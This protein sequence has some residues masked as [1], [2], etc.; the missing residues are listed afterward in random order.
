MKRLVLLSLCAFLASNGL[1]SV[2]RAM[3]QSHA[4]EASQNQAGASASAPARQPLFQ[5][6]YV[7]VSALPQPHDAPPLDFGDGKSAIRPFS[8]SGSSGVLLQGGL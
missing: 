4:Q 1:P 5:V 2:A 6:R 7:L 8:L 3:A